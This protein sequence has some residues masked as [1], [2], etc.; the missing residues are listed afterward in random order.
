MLVAVLMYFCLLGGYPL[1]DPDE[2]RYA[3]IAR[4][5]LESGDFVTPHLNYVKYLEKPPLFY[6]LVAASIA[7]LGE[8][9]LAVRTVSAI[10]G[11][12]SVLLVISLGRHLFGPRTG[13]AAGWIY[14]TSVQPFVLARLPII[15]LL[16]S[17]CLAATWGSWW[18]GYTATTMTEK[19]RWY[20]LAWTCL[21]LTTMSKGLAAIVLTGLIVLMFLL[22]R[23]DLSALRGMAWWP[24]LVIFAIIVAPWHLAVGQRNSEFWHFYIVVQH[25]ARLAG[26]EHVK[27]FW[28]FP[29]TL[30]FGMMFWGAF[31]FPAMAKALKSSFDTFKSPQTEPIEILGEGANCIFSDKS[32]DKGQPEAILFLVIWVIAVVGLFSLSKCKLFPYVLPS[33]PALALLVARHLNSK[34]LDGPSTGWCLCLTAVFLIGIILLLPYAARHQ[35]TVPYSEISGLVFLAQCLLSAGCGLVVFSIFERKMAIASLGLV[36]VL[37]MPVL[38]KSAGLITEYRKVGGLVKAMPNPLPADIKIAEWRTYDR[39]L[40]FYTRRRIILVDEVSELALR[41]T[42][43]D[44]DL[45]FLEGENHVRALA[46]DGPLLVNMRHKDWHTVKK[47]GVLF[48]VAANRTNLMVANKEFFALTALAPWPEE[49]LKSPQLLLLPRKA[50]GE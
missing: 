6:W 3:E 12:L 18:L 20:T 7:V 27:P 39:S 2:G 50:D 23:R 14:L 48:P 15:D 25:F 36:L 38:G 24:G 44:H 13:L 47:W 9:E 42:A 35:D 46:S 49:A 45:F 17:L 37:L 4:E 11:L 22:A 41:D 26:D 1:A 8:N 10:A 5:M 19:Q 34:A 30:P 32:K 16:F 31:L 28:F 40:G 43:K 29:A 33:Y 21:G